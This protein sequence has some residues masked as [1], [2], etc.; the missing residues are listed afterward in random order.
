MCRLLGYVADRP[1]SMVDLLGVESFEAFTSLTAVHGDG[2]GMAWHED[3]EKRTRTATSAQSAALDPRYTDLATHALGSAGM[4]H[5]RW[6][7]G[8]LAVSPM[9]T[10]PFVDGGYALAHNGNI[11]P[12]DS[13][14]ALLDADHHSRLVGD[15][16]SERYFQFVLQCIAESEDE[17]TGVAHA[18]KILHEEFPRSSL[19]A[20]L[21]TPTC[22]FAVHVNSDAVSPAPALHELFESDE[23]IPVGHETEYFAMSYRLTPDAV[24]VI[25]SG[26][27][28]KGWSPVLPDNAVM[29]DLATRVVTRLDPL[30]RQ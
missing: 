7:T 25:S 5:L 18:V 1:T 27:D 28:E 30:S 9:N 15:T 11:A 6:A 12:R 13:L 20:L 23:A 24:C 21:L 16:D 17:A 19:N 22:L 2:W 10:H 29:I 4:V 3:D 14:E 26:L 8:G